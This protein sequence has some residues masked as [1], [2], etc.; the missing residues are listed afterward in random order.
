MSEAV[1]IIGS[2]FQLLYCR[3]DWSKGL[4]VG[5]K[6]YLHPDGMEE[7]I[8]ELN[9]QLEIYRNT[10]RTI[11]Q[12]NKMQE[13]RMKELDRLLS[14]TQLRLEEIKNARQ[15]PAVI[16]FNTNQPDGSDSI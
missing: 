7:M 16:T 12:V 14:M 10:V 11:T 13:A 8:V 2:G 6:L 1:A 9:E 3:E 15:T 4:V 5:D